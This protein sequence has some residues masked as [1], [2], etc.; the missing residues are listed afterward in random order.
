L[1]WKEDK[2]PPADPDADGVT[3]KLSTDEALVLFSLLWRWV[4]DARASTPA[5]S[6]FESSGECAVLHGILCDLE[7]VLVAPFRRDG[8]DSFA[9]ARARLAVH[10][11]GR[12]LRG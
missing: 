8:G 2:Q 1:R 4:H 11:D 9:E 7:S 12:D 3:L 6:L 5:A 10:W